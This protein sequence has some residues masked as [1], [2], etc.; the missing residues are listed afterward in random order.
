MCFAKDVGLR[1]RG[2]IPAWVGRHFA[3]G[4]DLCAVP[5][6]LVDIVDV[7]DE[8]REIEVGVGCR[9]DGDV[10]AVPGVSGV[11][12]MLLV[13]PGFVGLDALPCGVIEGG[14][15]PG[16]GVAGVELPCSV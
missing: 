13:A 2:P 6:E 7:A 9:V 4:A 3:V 15:G 16:R 5:V 14:R 12:E 10:A 8:D 1:G 11:V